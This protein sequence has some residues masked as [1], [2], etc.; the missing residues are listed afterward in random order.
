M[1]AQKALTVTAAETGNIAGVLMPDQTTEDNNQRRAL[2]PELCFE[3]GC[4]GIAF[5]SWNP[6]DCDAAQRGPQFIE[7][8]VADVAADDEDS[9]CVSH[10]SMRALCVEAKSR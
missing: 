8:R 4:P 9:L 2:T 7:L 10:G 1:Q 6:L 3:S 5:A